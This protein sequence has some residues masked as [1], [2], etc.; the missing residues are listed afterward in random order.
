MD[1]DSVGAYLFDTIELG[2]QFRI[3]GGLRFDAINT[4]VRSFD[5]I[6]LFPAYV[7]DVER[8]RPRVELQRRLRLEAQPTSSVYLAYGTSFEPAGRVEVVLLSGRTNLPPVT[9]AALDADP[10]RSDAWELGGRVELFGGRATLSAAFQI[11]RENARTPGAN[12]TDPAVPFN[13]SQRVRGFEL[14]LVGELPPGWN[15]LAGY[16]YLDS[17][18]VTSAVAIE[19]GQP[20]DNTPR[21]SFNVWTSYR[22]TDQLTVGGGVQHV[23]SRVSGRPVGFL[24]VTVPSYTIGDLFAEY[25]FSDRLSARLNVFNVTDEYYFFRSSA[26]SRSPAWRDRPRCR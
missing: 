25:R 1:V 6:G 15:V 14:Q 22:V 18:I 23:G 4:R 20:L 11:T 16:A 3:I 26:T 19:I 8:H 24:T 13:G 2:E 5:D 17:E 21:H 10:E 7:E 12:P 9:A